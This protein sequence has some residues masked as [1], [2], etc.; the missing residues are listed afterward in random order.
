M[1][2]FSGIFTFISEHWLSALVFIGIFSVLIILHELG[3]FWAAQKAGV[4]VLEFGFGL[5]PKVWGTKTSR[6]IS[7]KKEEMEWTLN[8]IPFGGFVRLEGE[9]EK[10][11]SPNAFGNRPL[12]WRILVVCG[13][14]IM[15][16]ILGWGLLTLGYGLGMNPLSPSPEQKE[17]YVESGIWEKIEN[18][19]VITSLPKNEETGFK[20]FDIVENI[21][22][23][24]FSSPEDFQTFYDLAASQEKESIAV[25]VKRFNQETLS[26]ETHIEKISGKNS[27]FS[28]AQTQVEIQ[29]VAKDSPAEAL[30]FKKGDIIVALE[31]GKILNAQHFITSID[32]YFKKGKRTLRVTVLRKN[33]ENSEKLLTFIASL[34]A[35]GKIGIGIQN[36]QK[37]PE[38]NKIILENKT[39]YIPSQKVQYPWIE[40]PQK[41]YWESLRWMKLSFGMVTNVF[42]N[43]V[44]DQKIPEGI[45]GPVAIADTTDKLVDYGDWTKILQFMAILSLS[46]AVVNIM[47]FPGLDGGRLFFL[48]GEG[49][50]RIFS[51]LLFWTGLRKKELPTQLPEK[52]EMPLHAIG[53]FLLLGL[54]LWIT[55]NDIA[56]I[57]L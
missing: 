51:K 46:L 57:F 54:I 23:K 53:Y 22:G 19:T 8:A 11:D 6:E 48:L 30:G 27:P 44:F 17:H 14:V 52:Y 38:K 21:D 29:S 13:G 12:G 25:T 28:T 40:A 10:S 50:M 39:L 45:G 5:P 7:G 56:R 37:S 20:M 55:W 4:G 24:K 41:A 35:E 34:N 1:D 42:S 31:Q 16:F 36:I 9:E 18:E 15:N 49:I 2:F 33:T 32:R 47:P 3:H 43:I 26:F